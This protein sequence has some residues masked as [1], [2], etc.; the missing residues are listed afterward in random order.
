MKRFTQQILVLFG[1]C[2]VGP[3]PKTNNAATSEKVNCVKYSET[4]KN[5]FKYLKGELGS[6]SSDYFHSLDRDAPWIEILVLV[7]R[8][9]RKVEK[10][11]WIGL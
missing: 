5:L 2:L 3:A 4:V 10:S 9:N 6:T 1:L 11:W 7:Q 8:H